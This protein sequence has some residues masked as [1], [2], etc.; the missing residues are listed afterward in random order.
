MTWL[1][2]G[3]GNYPEKY[4]QTRHNAGFWFV[5]DLAKHFSLQFQSHKLSVQ[6]ASFNFDNQNIKIIKPNQFMNNSGISLA[7]IVHYYKIEKNKILVC[8]DEL[9][10]LP[11]VIKFKS[12]GSAAGHNGIKSIIQS[13]GFN[14]FYRLRIG[15]GRDNIYQKQNQSGKDY[16]L[17][18]PTSNEFNLIKN[19]FPKV[20]KAVE[21]LITDGIDKAML[22]LHT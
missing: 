2:A 8:Y 3:L 18:K 19:S 5:D 1:I 11:G 13:L 17:S 6:V 20:I 10:Y 12:S 7:E 16:V 14:D 21:I 15:I 22:Y 4:H 9:D